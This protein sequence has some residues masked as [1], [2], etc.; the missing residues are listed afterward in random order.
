MLEKMSI[1]GGLERRMQRV[2]VHGEALEFIL[3]RIM[4]FRVLMC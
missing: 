2:K 3:V 4:K 1:E